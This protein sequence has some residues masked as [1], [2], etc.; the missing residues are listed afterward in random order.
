MQRMDLGKFNSVH[1]VAACQFFNTIRMIS[2]DIIVCKCHLSFRQ[3]TQND[4]SLTYIYCIADDVLDY[5]CADFSCVCSTN[6]A[7]L[8]FRS[9][10]SL[11]V[12]VGLFNVMSGF[13]N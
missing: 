5:D 12:I 1:Q 3:P 10:T 13:L 2:N 11:G 6:C 8:V 4:T 7:T 9:L